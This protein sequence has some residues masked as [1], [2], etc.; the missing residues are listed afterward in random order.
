M[1]R[2]FLVPH[3]YFNRGGFYYS[4]LRVSDGA[5]GALLVR[6]GRLVLVHPGGPLR[7]SNG[8]PRVWIFSKFLVI[9]EVRLELLWPILGPLDLVIHLGKVSRLRIFSARAPELI[10]EPFFDRFREKREGF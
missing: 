3:L 10:W 1:R 6:F 9:L 2:A 7:N 4:D 5:F 8:R